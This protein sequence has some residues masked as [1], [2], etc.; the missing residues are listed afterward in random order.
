MERSKE[1]L[2]KN[3]MKTKAIILEDVCK[4]IMV[5]K[6][7]KM[8]NCESDLAENFTKLLKVIADVM[9]QNVDAINPFGSLSKA[10]SR[11][12]NMKQSPDES[13]YAYKDQRLQEVSVV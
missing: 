4:K 12:L 9:Y 13:V 3:T 10:L 7:H 1:T 11:L 2:R 6:L 8:K 5:D